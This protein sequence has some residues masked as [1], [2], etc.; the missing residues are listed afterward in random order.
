[1]WTNTTIVA[2]IPRSIW[3]GT[4]SCRVDSIVKRPTSARIEAAPLNELQ[5]VAPQSARFLVSNMEMSRDRVRLCQSEP[6]HHHEGRGHGFA[7]AVQRGPEARAM[8][9]F[10]AHHVL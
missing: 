7:A 4:M 1:M 6:D 5:G 10:P 2:A 3:I 8:H 9:K